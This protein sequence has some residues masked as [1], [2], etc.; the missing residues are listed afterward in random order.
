M[1][2]WIYGLSCY[3]LAMLYDKQ[4]K[5]EAALKMYKD[6]LPIYKEMH[7][8]EEVE[9]QEKIGKLR[10]ELFDSATS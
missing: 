7:A 6:C 3:R 2:Y 4:Y 9:I 10:K 8:K 5:M 1:K